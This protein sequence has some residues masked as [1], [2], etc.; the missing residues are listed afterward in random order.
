[1]GGKEGKERERVKLI[2]NNNYLATVCAYMYILDYETDLILLQR[3]VFL[4][5]KAKRAFLTLRD[6]E[7][8]HMVSWDGQ[9][10]KRINNQS[11]KH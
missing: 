3:L 2:T 1:M 9:E 6:V 11:Y 5:I 4:L 10:F 7:R 8:D